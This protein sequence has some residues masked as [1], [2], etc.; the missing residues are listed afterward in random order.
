MLAHWTEDTFF[1]P[2]TTIL[3]ADLK[4][5]VLELASYLEFATWY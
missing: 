3:T 4:V 2:L 5:A 1:V